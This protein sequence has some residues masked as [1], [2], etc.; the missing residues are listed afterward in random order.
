MMG[1]VRQEILSGV[2]TEDQFERLKEHLR[3]FPDLELETA[4]YEL[5]ASFSNRCRASGVQGSSVDFLICAAAD[6]RDLPVFTTDGDF[7]HFSKILPLK[8]LVP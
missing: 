8:L 7:A 5:A 4:D 6:R 3:P 1:P 2:R